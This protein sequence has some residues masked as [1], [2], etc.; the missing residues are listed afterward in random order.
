MILSG[1]MVS[2]Q[3]LPPE[4]QLAEDLQVSRPVLHQALVDLAGKGLV[5]I[6]P[7]RGVFVSDFQTS[8][9]CALLTALL[10]YHQGDLDPALMESLVEMRLLMEV[11]TAR[12]AARRR[13]EAHVQQFLALLDNEASADLSDAQALAEADF[14]FHQLVAQAS[15][16]FMY[17]LIIN[18]FK[19][20]YLNITLRFFAQHRD[21]K[22]PAEVF[23][24]HRR[25]VEAIA[26]QKS[27]SAAAIMTEMLQHG[28][29]HLEQ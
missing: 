1:Q 17:L 11:E 13:T 9:S 28:V 29:E 12:L 21:S 18:S 26:D 20:V 22:I 2:G 24:H 7:R 5:E 3:Q 25:L 10:T 19:P 14:L 8:G 4:R 27:E 6:V 15:G 16:N 23:A